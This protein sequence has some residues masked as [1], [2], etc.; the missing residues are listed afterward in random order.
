[1]EKKSYGADVSWILSAA[2]WQQDVQ[3]WWFCIYV[4]QAGLDGSE[5][6]FL[7]HDQ[8]LLFNL[9]NMKKALN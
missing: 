4:S 2:V 6:V 9:E 8:L 3:M 7:I 1:M 5:R